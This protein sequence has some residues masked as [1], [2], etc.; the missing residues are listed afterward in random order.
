MASG[1]VFKSLRFILYSGRA[2]GFEPELL[3]ITVVKLAA[4]NV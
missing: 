1:V 4:L 2:A 3:Y